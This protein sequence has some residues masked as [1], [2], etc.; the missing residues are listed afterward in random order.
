MPLT[1]LNYHH[2]FYFRTIA[3][4]GTVAKAATKLRL[5]QPTLS[6]QLM[7][8]EEAIGHKLFERRQKRLHLSEAGRMALEYANEIFRLGDEMLEALGDRL[9]AERIAVSIGAMDTVP[10]HLTLKL[11]EMAQSIHNCSVSVAEGHGDE[12]I[13]ELKAHR[14]DLLIANFSPPVAEGQGLFAKRIARMPVQICAARKYSH[15][16]RNFPQ[17]LDGQP[18]VMPSAGSRLRHD[19]DHFL[20]LAQ[21]RPVVSVEV[22]DTSLQKLLGSHGVGLI[23]IAAPAVEEFVQSKELVVL[24]ELPDVHEELWLIAAQRR[25]QNSVAARLMKDFSI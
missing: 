10:K 4:E 1:W 15:L 14:L 24:G 12:L 3:T 16:K 13:R 21:I 18:F 22:Q 9:S 25:I 6:T 11:V 2:L 8:F 23:P 20:K 7:Q 5:G 19:V 17:S